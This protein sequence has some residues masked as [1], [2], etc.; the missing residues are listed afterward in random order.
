[1]KILL[2]AVGTT[3]DVLPFIAL[4]AELKKRGHSVTINTHDDFEDLVKYHNLDF[5]LVGGSFKQLA[6]SKEGKAWLESGDNVI[7]YMSTARKLF[8]PIFSEWV[9]VDRII[10]GF[11]AI[12][13]HPFAVYAY[14]T[15]EK[16]KLP[17]VIVSLIPWFISGAIEPIMV[18][19][20]S[21]FFKSWVN[22]TLNKLTIQSL[23]SLF[24]DL[25]RA[26]RRE[27]GLPPTKPDNLW[28]YLHKIG[29]PHIHLYSP[30]L[31]KEPPDFPAY[32]RVS[33]FC[34]LN[35]KHDFKPP[36]SLTDFLAQGKQ[37]VYIGFG[38]MTG[39]D[40]VQ[41]TRMTV[42]AVKKTKQRAVL[43]TGWGGM[44][45]P[46]KE[47]DILII[48]SAPHDW[49]FPRVKALIHHGGIGTTAAG[50]RAGKPM[51]IVAFF[52]DQPFWGR[53]IHALQV[54][55]K[56]MVKKDL[57]VNHLADLIKKVCNNTRYEKNAQRVG[58][59]IRKEQGAKKAADLILAYAKSGKLIKAK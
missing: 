20:V 27:L 8:K 59:A 17:F 50:L 24:K 42:E 26:K 54:G 44:E 5:E 47:K 2:I 37:P 23:W 32:C 11:D 58:E 41:L 30:S 33:G 15:A 28:L 45:N 31:L 22:K 7:K 38:S 29:I 34:F 53:R 56:P 48:D 52:G 19:I 21:P 13:A 49:L 35:L 16:H 25:S 3:G 14:H 57:N 55:P 12:I 6:E 39:K 4:G 43:L 36:S 18:P 1:M 51:G 10:P 9:K 40:P 46:P